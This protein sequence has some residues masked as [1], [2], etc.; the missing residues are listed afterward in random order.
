MSSTSWTARAIS[1][2]IAALRDA[3]YQ[4]PVDYLG[5]ADSGDR[6]ADMA[7]NYWAG[8]DARQKEEEQQMDGTDREAG[9]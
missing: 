8:R 7:R 6:P 4:G 2:R 5:Y 1:A 9:Q 3:G